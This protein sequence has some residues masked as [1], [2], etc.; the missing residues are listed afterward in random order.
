MREGPLVTFTLLAQ[1]AAGTYG[2]LAGS[3][4]AAA[5]A[6]LPGPAYLNRGAL[7]FV[8]ALAALAML[9]SFLHLGTPRRAYRAVLNLRSSWLSREI[10]TVSL[11]AGCVALQA[12]YTLVQDPGTLSPAILLFTSV[13][14]LALVF[15]IS[16][17]YMLRTM[18]AWNSW[19]TFVSFLS[20]ALLLGSMAAL[21]LWSAQEP[22]SRPGG[23]ASAVDGAIPVLAGLC[24]A[25]EVV[26]VFRRNRFAARAPRYGDLHARP[27]ASP[28]VRLLAGVL[29]VLGFALAV[30]ALGA[31]AQ[32]LGLV[33]ALI[34]TA[35]AETVNRFGFYVG[36]L[37]GRRS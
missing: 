34:V 4:L 10:F 12:G 19:S 23:Q 17:V 16:R 33:A 18:P 3:Q 37:G 1:A 2:V 7:L 5:A 36:T 31:A 28:R 29:L 26:L 14:A 21:V 13:V 22:A 11:F 25:L 30:L 27:E 24:L 9:A 32:A 15:C 35:A 8:L 20:A 6:G